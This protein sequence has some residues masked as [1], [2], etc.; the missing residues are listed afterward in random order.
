MGNVQVN[1]EAL[2]A[3]G[4]GELFTIGTALKNAKAYIE[5]NGGSI[6][7]LQIDEAIEIL[8]TIITEGF[9]SV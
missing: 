2:N 6:D 8:D 1:I 5:E 3:D 7:D 4:V 9:A